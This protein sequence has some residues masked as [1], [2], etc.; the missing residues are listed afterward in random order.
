[1][2]TFLHAIAIGD[3]QGQRWERVEALVGTR[4][5]Y[6]VLP[7]TFLHRLGVTPIEQRPFELAGGKIIN[8]PVGQTWVRVDGKSGIRI[9]VFSPE[10][11]YILGAETLSGFL[12][13]VD[14]LGKRLVPVKGLLM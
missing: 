10:E 9:V 7:A 1:M 6:T 11:V 2:G 5:S 3:P 13:E 12:L 4:A 8:L 14:P